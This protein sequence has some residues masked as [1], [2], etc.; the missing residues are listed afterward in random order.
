[1]I[2]YIQVK[3]ILNTVKGSDDWFGLKY[4]LNLYRGCT[5]RCIY[6]DSRSECYQI[7]NFD[8]DIIV[9]ENALELLQKELPKKRV[10]GTVGFGSMN[11]PYQHIEKK[12]NM[13][14]RALEIMREWDMPVHLITKSNLVLRDIR[15]LKEIGKI[16]SAVSFTITTGITLMPVLPFI[17]DT[18]DNIIS[19]VEKAKEYGA[20]YIIPAFG[21]TLRDRQR[22]YYYDRLDEKFPGLSDK[23]RA[24]YKNYYSAGAPGYKKLS[25]VFYEKCAELGILTKIPKYNAGIGI[26]GTLF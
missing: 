9:K 21:M 26:Q 17:T 2:K 11:D 23:Y 12:L 20:K 6:C 3:T 4:N 14:V 1:M 8:H 25:K 18:E 10:R 7:E 19:I 13:T 5:H 24:K 16:Y 22:A 15:I